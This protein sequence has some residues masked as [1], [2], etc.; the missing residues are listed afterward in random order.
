MVKLLTLLF[1]GSYWQKSLK[2]GIQNQALNVLKYYQVGLTVDPKLAFD[3]FMQRSAL[4][5]YAFVWETA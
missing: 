5:H 2:L 4:D 3:R 1:F